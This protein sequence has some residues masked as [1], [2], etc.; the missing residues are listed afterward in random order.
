MADTVVRSCRSRQDSFE[1]IVHELVTHHILRLD[2][3]MIGQ[4]HRLDLELQA[5]AMNLLRPNWCCHEH[6]L[7]R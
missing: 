4:L 6:L 7:N 3:R 5:V 1:A 2:V